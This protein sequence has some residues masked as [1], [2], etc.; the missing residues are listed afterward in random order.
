[1]LRPLTL[2]GVWAAAAVL[3]PVAQN[4]GSFGTV[5]L[6]YHLRAGDVML[7]T[8]HLLRTNPFAFTVAGRPWTDQQWGAQI[9]LGGFFRVFGWGGIAVLQSLLVAAIFL[10]VLKACRAAGA[11]PRIAGWVTLG[12]AAGARFDLAFRPQMLGAVLFAATLWLVADRRNHPRRLWLAPVLIALWANIHGSFFLGPLLLFLAAVQDRAERSPMAKRTLLIG[13]V[14]LLA[15]LLNPFGP[16]VWGYLVSI[17][18][19]AQISGAISEWQSPTLR[20]PDGI[21]FF[22]SVLVV[23]LILVRRSRAVTWSTLLTTA[24]FLLIGVSARRSEMWWALGVAPVLC[25]VLARSA[26]PRSEPRN[27]PEINAV[28]V[29]ILV[30][31]VFATFPYSLLGASRNYP[32]SRI[33]LSVPGITATLEREA[34]PGE[35]IF[36][37]QELGSWLEFAVPRNPVFIDSV[38]EVYPAWIWRENRDISAGRQGWQNDLARW[39]V[40]ILVLNQELNGRLIPLVLQSPDWRLI[41]RDKDGMV[42]VSTQPPS[43]TSPT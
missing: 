34:R 14:A 15:T 19:N 37:S 41:Y 6:A 35:R 3:L 24:V 1:L 27:L 13:V 39:K 42:F 21:I 20:E 36:N 23:V 12:A 10:F 33:Y 22:A 4:H 11:E 30:V 29:G 2:G 31:A 7:N 9:I 8:H 16:G 32:G 5:D 40:R 38:I 26:R 43:G 28:F 17:S 25:G 18:T